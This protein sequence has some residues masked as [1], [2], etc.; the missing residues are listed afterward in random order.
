MDALRDLLSLA[1]ALGGDRFAC[2]GPSALLSGPTSFALESD[3]DVADVDVTDVG[4]GANVAGPVDNLTRCAYVCAGERLLSV[5]VYDFMRVLYSRRLP[6]QLECDLPRVRCTV[7][8]IRVRTTDQ[9]RAAVAAVDESYLHA[10][11]PFATQTVMALPLRLLHAACG[12]ECLVADARGPLEVAFV[13]SERFW[14]VRALKRLR[15]LPSAGD[16]AAHDEGGRLLDVCVVYE[17]LAAS[18]IVHWCDA[19]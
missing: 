7:N 1:L 17:C 4:A 3:P 16:A 15:V 5:C 19:P 18:V 13:V 2:V 14:T 8:G 9:L 6:R 10:L 12:P 11:A